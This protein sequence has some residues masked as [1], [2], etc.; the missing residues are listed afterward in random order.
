MYRLSYHNLWIR[1]LDRNLTG[2]LSLRPFYHFP[3][4][5]KEYSIAVEGFHLLHFSHKIYYSL[6]SDSGLIL[7]SPIPVLAVVDIEHV[8]VAAD[9]YINNTVVYIEHVMVAADRYK[10]NTV[11]DIEHVMVAAD[12]Y[13][14]QHKYEQIDSGAQRI[15]EC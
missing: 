1:S 6:V 5:K 3:T 4:T 2:R 9:R 14:K 8:M 12:R 10:N 11:V 13:R 7:A 15:F